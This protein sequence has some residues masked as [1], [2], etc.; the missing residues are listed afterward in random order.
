[1]W[2][3]VK[4][5]SQSCFGSGRKTGL[6]ECF[7]QSN[8]CSASPVDRGIHVFG[9][10]ADHTELSRPE[11]VAYFF[12]RCSA[13]SHFKVMNRRGAIHRYG[14]HQAVLHQIV[15]HG[16]ESDFDNVSSEA[17]D[18]CSVRGLC[19]EDGSNQIPQAFPSEN[20]RQL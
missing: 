13:H 12:G 4:L 16:P 18:D 15:D 10:F 2:L 1:M 8:S 5:D 3:V 9:C 14:R 19:V 20:A 11:N 6:A 7:A 17:P